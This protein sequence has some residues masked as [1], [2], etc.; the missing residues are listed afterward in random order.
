[1]KYG[2]GNYINIHILQRLSF[3]IGIRQ[4]KSTS[5]KYSNFSLR[6]EET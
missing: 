5:L 4:K 3:E 6:K 1:M 2:I